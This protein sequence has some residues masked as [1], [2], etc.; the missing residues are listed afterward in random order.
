MFFEVL[1]HGRDTSKAC[2]TFNSKHN[3]DI[4]HLA[5]NRPDILKDAEQRKYNIS[6]G[7]ITYFFR[8]E[9]FLKNMQHIF[10]ANLQELGR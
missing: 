9:N 7:I 1:T 2:V 5:G 6:R 4:T 3:N 10:Q 8:S